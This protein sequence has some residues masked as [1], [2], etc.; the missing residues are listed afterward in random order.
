MLLKSSV[1]NT[2]IGISV[3]NTRFLLC[4]HCDVETGLY[5]C[6]SRYYNPEW[7]RWI[8]PDSID[9]LNPESINGLNLYV[10]AGNNPISGNHNYQSSGFYNS[11]NSI[12]IDYSSEMNTYNGKG[13][14]SKLPWLVS[15][16]T[17]IYGLYANVSTMF[18]TSPFL[19]KYGKTFANEMRLYG[20]S[21][22]KGALALSGFNWTIGKTDGIM[23]GIDVGLDIYD[24]IQRGVSTG[25]VVLGAGLT[26]GKDV[27]LLYANKGIMWAATTIG[28]FAGPAGT[29]VG[30]VVG[31]V[32]C[33]LTDI[34]VG[35]WLDDLIDQWAK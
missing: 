23:M 1:N 20:I 33:I 34:F 30:F 35:G 21:N 9:Y 25:G 4:K 6:N 15:S 8:S 12:G 24:S 3:L 14:L 16:G 31:G 27:A 7:G 11:Q 28:S 26:L 32:V 29:A 18:K 2:S 10:Y 22:S 13:K 19:F 17:S 5:Y